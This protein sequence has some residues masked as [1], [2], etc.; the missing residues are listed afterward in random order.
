MFQSLA[1][2]FRHGV[3]V[4]LPARH[5]HHIRSAVGQR[6]RDSPSDP[7]PAAGDDRHQAVQPEFVVHIHIAPPRLC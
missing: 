1:N 5:D 4:R 6:Q 2:L 3:D 7:T